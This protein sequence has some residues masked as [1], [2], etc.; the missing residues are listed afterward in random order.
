MLRVH[1]TGS[2]RSE[3]HYKIPM[4]EKAQYLSSVMRQL[5]TKEESQE[6]ESV[7]MNL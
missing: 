1:K 4:S 3:G 2:A 5:E 7:R 6:K